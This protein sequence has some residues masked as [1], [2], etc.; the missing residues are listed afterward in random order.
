MSAEMVVRGAVI[1]ALKADA[2]LMDRVNGL[3]DGMPVRATSPYAVVG[4]CLGSDWSA[5]DIEGRELRLTI[6]LR[7]AAETTGR[8]ADML[9]R[10][11][12]AIR[13]VAGAVDGWRIVTASLLRSRV[14][15]VDARGE[16][17]W[18]ALVDYR[19]RAVREE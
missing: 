5:K 17:G 14:A 6:S 2:G 10:I 19:I 16:T 9:A 13:S 4:E 11:E 15:R 3:Y 8:L 12:P 1:A 7:D 18:Q